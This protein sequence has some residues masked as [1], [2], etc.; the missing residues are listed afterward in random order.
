VKIDARVIGSGQPGPV[1]AKLVAQYHQ[2]TQV[3]GEPI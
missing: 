3:S 2:L 1:T